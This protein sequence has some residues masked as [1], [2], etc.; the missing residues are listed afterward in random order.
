MAD[1][2][3]FFHELSARR[4]ALFNLAIYSA[5]L[6]FLVGMTFLIPGA[7]ESRVWVWGLAAVGGL[8]ALFIV[9]MFVPLAIRGGTYRVTVWAGRLR[10][11]SPHGLFGRS[12]QVSLSD[13]SQ[14][15]VRG[16]SDGPTRHEIQTR[17]GE[18][19]CLDAPA[20][21]AATPTAYSMQ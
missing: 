10:V 15:M 12:F 3:D 21:V 7:R 6:G 16:L 9:P 2:P 18:K 11:E 5:S 8:N 4:H 14:L 1:D 13:I 19:F 17:H 20:R